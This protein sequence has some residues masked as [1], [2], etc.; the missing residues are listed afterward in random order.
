VEKIQRE[1]IEISK[2]VKE[3]EAGN[4]KLKQELQGVQ[5]DNEK[6]GETRNYHLETMREC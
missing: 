5:R 1:T 2:N 3:A 6:L 4:T